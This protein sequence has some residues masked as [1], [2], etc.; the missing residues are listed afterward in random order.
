MVFMGKNTASMSARVAQITKDLDAK[1]KRQDAV[2]GM[3]R[4]IVRDCS[5]AIKYLHD[6]TSDSN[7][8][9]KRIIS[10]LTDKIHDV[11][12]ESLEDFERISS[13]ALQEYAEVRCLQSFLARESV[14]TDEELGID[15][16]SWLNGLADCSGELRRA[17]Q[18]ALRDGRKKDAEYYFESLNA[19]HDELMTLKYSSSL[20]GGLRRK[21]DVLRGQIEAARSELLRASS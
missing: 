8:E 9:A 2:L 1:E 5:K 15:A 11:K 4:E 12:K 7:Q 17:L 16:L 14:P 13:T 20:V 3:S 10:E 6:G 18:L 19:I 21:Q